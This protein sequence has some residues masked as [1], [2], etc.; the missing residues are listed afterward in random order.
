LAKETSCD[1]TWS[2][3]PF[4]FDLSGEFYTLIMNRT[5]EQRLPKVPRP[6]WLAIVTAWA[7]LSLPLTTVSAADAIYVRSDGSDDSS[8]R[9][10]LQAV[11]TIQ[12]A[13]SIASDGATVFVESGNYSESLKLGPSLAAKGITL[14]ADS[15]GASAGKAGL[16]RLDGIECSGT[17]WL[18]VVGFTVEGTVTA[19]SVS[20]L[21]LRNCMLNHAKAVGCFVQQASSVQ[22]VGCSI[23]DSGGDALVMQDVANLEVHDCIVRDNRG[24]GLKHLSGGFASISRTE[25][26]KNQ[27]AMQ[28]SVPAVLRSC[29]VVDNLRGIVVGVSH[30]QI[31]HATIAFNRGA[32]I[33]CGEH[34]E[35]GITNSIIAFNG[36]GVVNERTPT[37]E[38]IHSPWLSRNLWYH[39]GKSISKEQLPSD[40]LVI[41]PGFVNAQ[42]RDLRLAAHSPARDVGGHTPGMTDFSGAPRAVGELPD[43]GC[44]ESRP[45]PGTTF[46]VS[47]A[48]DN[49]SSGLHPNNA[50]ATLSRAVKV[51]GPGD[52]VYVEAGIYTQAV[53]F[54]Q[55]GKQDAE[56]KFVGDNT[57][58]H[59][60]KKGPVILQRDEEDGAIL[61]FS[62]AAHISMTGFQFLS[63]SNNQSG[64]GVA[65]SHSESIVFRQCEW[66]GGG[67][68]VSLLGSS[69]NLNEC[70]LNGAGQHGISIRLSTVEATKC[71]VSDCDIGL[72][73]GRDGAAAMDDCRFTDNRTA[74]VYA[75]GR[76]Q[77]KDCHV[78]KNDNAGIVIY[79][80]DSSQLNA[81]NL[82]VTQNGK[83]GGTF[84]DCLLLP[85]QSACTSWKLSSNPCCVLVS[86]GV[87]SLAAPT[88]GDSSQVGIQVQA[89]S[90]HVQ[91]G[92]IAS[93]NY[94][95]L[96]EGSGTV[97]LSRCV[98][99][100]EGTGTAFVA[101][102]GDARL[103][104]CIVKNFR[105]GISSSQSCRTTITNCT[106][107][108]IAVTGIDLRQGSIELFN[109]I[110]SGTQQSASR[111]LRMDGFASCTHTHNLIHGFE[112]AI[113]GAEIDKTE[114]TSD[115]RFVDVLE[116]DFHLAAG[117]A[118]INSGIDRQLDCIDDFDGSKRPSHSVYEIGAFEYTSG[119]GSFRILKWVEK[120]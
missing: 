102:A 10:P 65:I 114:V 45:T 9:S 104:N 92:Y 39:N 52:T 33:D 77:L 6:L 40:E 38:G 16:V 108:K 23:S 47:S 98:L 118:A 74:G 42:Q 31:E 32:A 11:A 111:G 89:G 12:H 20:H 28:L 72:Y 51:A 2:D 60:S 46:Y 73:I 95:V 25:F 43:L 18:Q 4:A 37:E 7:L 94:G 97:N 53:N 48:G 41:D 119:G 113:D 44:W 96:A 109:T 76:C 22:L 58:E 75:S 112:S 100:G 69:A 19:K 107:A 50:W 56:V 101:N 115:P 99:A 90:L 27:A 68:C 79:G 36:E 116:D 83:Y 110:I 71:L 49:T 24:D 15:R 1:V 14:F 3:D 120:R 67:S 63:P 88:I 106:L 55:R 54:Q 62:N 85:D 82:Q 5:G 66:V 29:L 78:T 93:G 86:G 84:A 105:T 80:L 91:R 21:S 81:S 87:V 26:R 103:V 8:G 13:L 59:F 64:F 35:V 57:G 61:A 70:A 117:S 17:D 30:A 34:R